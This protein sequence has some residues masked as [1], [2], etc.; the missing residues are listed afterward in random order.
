MNEKPFEEFEPYVYTVTKTVW[1]Q[2]KSELTFDTY[3]E[4]THVFDEC[5]RSYEEAK[6]AVLED[7]DWYEVSFRWVTPTNYVWYNPDKSETEEGGI[8]YSIGKYDPKD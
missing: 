4:S 2:S 7:A 1:R 3:R 8:R 5:F 6:D